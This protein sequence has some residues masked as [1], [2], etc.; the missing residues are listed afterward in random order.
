MT[1]TDLAVVPC[2]QCLSPAA[3]VI[4]A[5]V[6]RRRGWYCP[7]CGHFKPAIGREHKVK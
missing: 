3:Q 4:Y 5:A 7:K 1:S 6:N 2:P